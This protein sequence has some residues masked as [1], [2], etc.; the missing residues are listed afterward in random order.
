MDKCAK[1]QCCFLAVGSH[2]NG[3]NYHCNLEW[4]NN[5]S[6]IVH[7]SKLGP[8][9]EILSPQFPHKSSIGPAPLRLIDGRQSRPT[10]LSLPAM[11]API[12]PLTRQPPATYHQTSSGNS[13]YGRAR[14]ERESNR[15]LPSH[16]CLRFQH[17]SRS[18]PESP[19]QARVASTKATNRTWDEW[20]RSG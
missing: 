12:T 1:R 7:R 18:G 4:K 2:P 8:R 3:R 6:G 11:T 14:H 15:R 19:L 16:P 13:S 20:I 10:N 5:E 17:Q 9:C